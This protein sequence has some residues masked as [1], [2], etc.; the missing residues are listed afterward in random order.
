MA[1]SLS[2]LTACESVET[3]ADNSRAAYQQSTAVNPFIRENYKAADAL[4]AQLSGKLRAEQPLII[5]TT[6]NINALEQ[7]S[8]LGRLISEQ[9]AARFSQSGL[10]L[11]EIK[12]R[13][14]MYVKQDQG[15]LM[16]TREINEIARKQNSQAVIVG[17]Y[18]ES[19]DDVFV[20][21]KVIQPNTNI[22]LAVHD[23]AIPKNKNVISLLRSKPL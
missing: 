8:T 13:D 7:S 2:L 12:F 5:A 18:G 3:R 1:A 10:K 14:S 9:V 6:V 15:E 21:L 16:L 17:T 22:V 4:L 11:I 23:F 19:T 20:N